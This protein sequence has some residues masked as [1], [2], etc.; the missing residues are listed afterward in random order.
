MMSP[1]TSLQANY[2][3]HANKG[4]NIYKTVSLNTIV[5]GDVTG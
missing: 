2:V 5:F 3:E 1:V 4:M